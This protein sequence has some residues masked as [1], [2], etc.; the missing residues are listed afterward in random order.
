MVMGPDQPSLNPFLRE[1]L[2]ARTSARSHIV[3][4]S[5]AMVQKKTN[6]SPASSE[7]IAFRDTALG[8]INLIFHRGKNF[9]QDR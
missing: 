9:C 6:G 5:Q 4:G 1:L 7:N 8:T 2:R 3:R